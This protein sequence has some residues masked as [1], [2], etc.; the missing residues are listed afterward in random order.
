MTLYKPSIY[1]ILLIINLVTGVNAAS[2]GA[3]SRAFLGIN[4]ASGSAPGGPVEGVTVVGVTPGGPA[5]KAGLVVDDVIVEI[6]GVSL[7]A[8]SERSANRA[9]FG[10]MKKVSPGDQ[11]PIVY[12]RDGKALETEL[13]AAQLDP[14]LVPPSGAPFWDELERFGRRFGDEV[15][16]PLRFRWRHQGIFRGMELIELTAD[17]GRYFGAESG[18]LVLRAPQDDALGLKDGDVI[19]SIGERTPKNAGHA[20]RILRSYEPGETVVIEI[21]RDKRD[22][23]VSMVMPGEASEPD[24]DT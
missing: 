19:R 1:L 15:V 10:F 12:L 4:I 9:L 23:K 18:L 8:D 21:K 6:S 17:L 7:T 3:A 24:S 14:E 5:Q 2:H 13:V 11:L 16:D 22:R 20:M